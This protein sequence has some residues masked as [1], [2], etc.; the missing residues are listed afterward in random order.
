RGR[1]LAGLNRADEAL[2]DLNQAVELQSNDALVYAARAGILEERGAT[3]EARSDLEKSLGLERT[4]QAA[5]RMADLL[6]P[7]IHAKTKLMV[8]TSETEGVT[9][10]FTTTRPSDDWM[11]EAFDDSSWSTAP[12]AFGN[13]SGPGPFVRT[14]WKTSDI[15]LR[16]VIEWKPDPAIEALLLRI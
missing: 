4:E 10:R 3:E 15:W 16:R 14:A 6:L 9:W 13:G 5:R 1:I 11:A 7:R 2:A 8:P 12:G